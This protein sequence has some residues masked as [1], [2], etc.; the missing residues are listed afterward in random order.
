MSDDAAKTSGT[1]WV[2]TRQSFPE[3]FIARDLL[4][5]PERPTALISTNNR[6]TA[7]AHEAVQVAR[8]MISI[9]G[10]DDFEL[11]DLLGVSVVSHDAE[12]MGAH[13]ADLLLAR[14][15][16]D[17]SETHHIVLPTSLLERPARGPYGLRLV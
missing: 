6:I 8:S 13:A 2:T 10:F 16:G 7:G 9:I 3:V 1:M 4:S 5:L 17:V 14:L 15:A 11:A 12:E